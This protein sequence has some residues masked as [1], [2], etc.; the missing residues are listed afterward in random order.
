M[1]R[2]HNQTIS[3]GIWYNSFLNS[4]LPGKLGRI[5]LFLFLLKQIL[6]V[7]ILNICQN[8]VWG[9]GEAWK[10]NTDWNGGDGEG[11]TI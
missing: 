7:F 6:R 5:F 2:I 11:R 3:N 10:N 9:V 8:M 1:M 4:S